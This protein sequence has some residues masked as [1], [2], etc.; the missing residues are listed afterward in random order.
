MAAYAFIALW[1]AR[2]G[3]HIFQEVQR[4]FKHASEYSSD[5]C[6]NQGGCQ[7]AELQRTCTVF[8]FFFFK[9]E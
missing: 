7:I 3:M 6:L 4:A 9:K 2:L 8:L 5:V 1:E